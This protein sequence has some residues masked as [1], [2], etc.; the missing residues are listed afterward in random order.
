[1]WFSAGGVVYCR[2]RGLLQVWFTAERR[3][4]LQRGV[5]YCRRALLTAGGIVYYRGAWFTAERRD[6]LQ[7]WFTAG[8]AA[9]CLGKGGKQLTGWCWLVGSHRSSTQGA[10]GCTSILVCIFNIE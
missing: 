1:M 9:R 8:V 7:V 6:L 4:L 3:G 2:G 10:S 5:V